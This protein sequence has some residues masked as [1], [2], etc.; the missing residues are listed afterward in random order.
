[1]KLKEEI[2][3]VQPPSES[4]ST[5]PVVIIT[6]VL[7]VVTIVIVI[8]ATSIMVLKLILKSRQSTV[9]RKESR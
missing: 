6:V 4:G 8:A 2:E 3:L 5:D 7:G 1:M 9:D